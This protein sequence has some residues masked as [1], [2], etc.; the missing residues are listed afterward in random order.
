MKIGGSLGRGYK[1][2]GPSLDRLRTDLIRSPL[3]PLAEGRA[4]VESREHA[5]RS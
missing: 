3:V 2:R 1:I 5:R 4:L